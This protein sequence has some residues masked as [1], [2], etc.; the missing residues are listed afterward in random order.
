MIMSKSKPIKK[1][2]VSITAPVLED[3]KN[4]SYVFP[5]WLPIGFV[6]L[7]TFLVFFPTLQN[8]FVNWD[9]DVNILQNR[10]LE[11]ALT[12]AKCKDIFTHTI[13][14]GYNPLSIFTFAL[15]KAAFGVENW[16]KV[17]HTNNL[18]LHL[19][20]VYLVYQLVLML[21]WDTWTAFFTALLFGIH[22]MRVESVAWATERKD[23]LLGIFYFLAIIQYVKHL[24]S[25]DNKNLILTY[26]YFILALFSKIQAVALPLTLLVFDYYLDKNLK[27]AL[28]QKIPFFLIAL[29]WGISSI[30][31]LKAAKTIQIDSDIVQF[32]F[33]ER[34]GIAGYAYLIYLVKWIYPYIMACVYPY[35]A[36]IPPYFYVGTL[37]GI[38]SIGL[39]YQQ[40]LKQNKL[41][42]FGFVFF[43]FNFMFVSQ[44]VGAGQAF[45]ADR[46]T[47]IAYFGLFLMMIGFLNHYKK[48]Y[49]MM[50][51][52]L[53]SLYLIICCTMTY[54][55]VQTW[56]NGE[57]LWTQ[58]MKYDSKTSLPYGNRAIYYRE[59]KDFKKALPDFDKAIA[60]SGKAG[61]LNSRGKTYFDMGQ[62]DKAIADY[63]VA[64]SKDTTI[65][66]IWVNRAAAF[67]KAGQYEAALSDANKGLRLDNKLL[68][69]YGMR[70]LIYQS[71]GNFEAALADNATYLQLKPDDADT[72]FDSGILSRQLKQDAAALGHFTKAIGLN[73]QK[74]EY[75]LERAKLYAVMGNVEA[76]NQDILVA[77]SRGLVIPT[78][79]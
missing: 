60:L 16:S 18:C 61:T 34:L 63:N 11:G 35:P 70:S 28:I 2:K 66:E 67:G 33:L 31:F 43:I 54:A 45:L 23:V 26:L 68:N 65:G 56:K 39:I 5:N 24:K 20:V 50:V 58:A 4:N 59:K 8:D 7:A 57:T 3:K 74:G 69:G 41:I 9:D 42:V 78:G 79:L 30:W 6:L 37:L 46:F 75:Y 73:P 32:N 14:G 44:I 71:M 15:E 55:Q 47:Y 25:N 21:N 17:I 38:A 62:N 36:K 51:N 27:K 64:L 10:D 53:L 12:F 13:M 19:G 52:G 22:P 40:Y 1:Q 48:Q 49:Q 77:K 76:K 72:W 29:F